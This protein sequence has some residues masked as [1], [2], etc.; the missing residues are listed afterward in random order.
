MIDSSKIQMQVIMEN[1]NLLWIK[2]SLM[3]TLKYRNLFSHTKYST[4]KDRL[5]GRVQK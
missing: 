5:E 3:I 2:S 1:I 4:Y